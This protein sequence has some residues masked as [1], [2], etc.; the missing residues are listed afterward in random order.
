MVYSGGF[1]AGG[2]VRAE[3]AVQGILGA[4]SPQSRGTAWG[5]L[6]PRK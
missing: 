6:R 4:A 2:A 3:G 1:G 5:A